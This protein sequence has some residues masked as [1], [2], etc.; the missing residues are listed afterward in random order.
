MIEKE[1]QTIEEKPIETIDNPTILD[2][3]GDCLALL[4][5]KNVVILPKSILPIIVGRKQSI[6]AV[7][8][9]LKQNKA[10]FITAQR[11]S[12][13]EEPTEKDVFHFGTR[14][15]IL[16]VM[17]MPNG[18]LKILAEGICRSEIVCIKRNDGFMGVEYK[19][20]PTTDLD[21]TNVENEALWRQLKHLYETYAKLNEKVPEDLITVAKTAKEMDYI[22]DTIA[23]HIHLSFDE[24]QIILET[25]SLKERM[26]KLCKYLTKEIEI[27]QT[28]Q[29][30]KGRIQQQVEK[31]QREYYLNE[32]IK[33]IQKELGR[34]DQTV[35]LNELCE[36]AKKLKLSPEAREKVDKE[37]HRLEQMPPLLQKLSSAA[38]MLI[39]SCPCHGAKQLKIRL[40][41][42]K[43]KKS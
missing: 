28:E 13:I 20:I 5:L 33:A 31:G 1:K 42:N 26:L 23:I 27:L 18:A 38:T 36:K 16:Q 3:E 9:A 24:R 4:P 30:I 2:A 21:E 34:E 11:D 7:E 29:R 25:P 10:L 35:E 17:R 6:Q 19:D 32:Q 43:R 40:A 37:F 14:S 12:K 39:G 15:V 22:V 8:Y 41:L